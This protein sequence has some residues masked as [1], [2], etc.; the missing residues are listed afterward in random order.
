VL[1][2]LINLVVLELLVRG[3][4]GDIPSQALAVA[5][6]MPFNF[7]GNKLFTFDE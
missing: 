4:M 6:A 7:V 5:V 1:A 2:L 3:G